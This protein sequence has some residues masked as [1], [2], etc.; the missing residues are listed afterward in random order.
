MSEQLKSEKQTWAETKRHGSRK[1]RRA[2]VSVQVGRIADRLLERSRGLKSDSVNYPTN[3]ITT[4]FK[5]NGATEGN[6]V[7][8]SERMHLWSSGD[9]RYYERGEDTTQIGL[10]EKTVKP[11]LRKAR[12]EKKVDIVRHGVKRSSSGNSGSEEH[13]LYQLTVDPEGKRKPMAYTRDI[14]ANGQGPYEHS[15]APS[16]GSIVGVAAPELYEIK[17]G[18][19]RAQPI[20]GR[21]AA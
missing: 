18:I 5:F 19:D 13:H 17:K 15:Y 21:K 9:P 7:A 14:Y 20:S 4:G 12:Q 6:N 16:A 2:A 11:F 3:A 8:T 1:E 10:R